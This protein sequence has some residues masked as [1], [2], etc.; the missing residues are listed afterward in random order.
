[1]RMSAIIFVGLLLVGCRSSQPGS[2]LSSI[3]AT[4]LARQLANDKADAIYHHRPFLDG[5]P[6]QFVTGKWVWSDGCGVALVDY[7]ASVTLA[8]D[9]S[10]NRVDIQLWDD[11]SRPIPV[12][13][14]PPAQSIP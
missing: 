8:A 1:M 4:A 5:Q 3:Q 9:G 14:L 7:R 11:T 10:T 13:S 12:R 6:A 2:S